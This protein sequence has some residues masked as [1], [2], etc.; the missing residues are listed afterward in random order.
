VAL[1]DLTYEEVAAALG[2]AYGRA[3]E[4]I[5]FG[6][7]EVQGYALVPDGDHQLTRLDSCAGV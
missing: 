1:A 2:I 3:V 5:P 4:V 6:R 7:L